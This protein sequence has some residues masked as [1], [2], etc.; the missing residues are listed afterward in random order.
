MEQNT[1]TT[2]SGK[3]HGTPGNSARLELA[4]LVMP[5]DLSVNGSKLQQVNVI[6]R[7]NGKVGQRWQ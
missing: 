7:R 6:K 5:Q 1:G 4:T 3:L 2:G